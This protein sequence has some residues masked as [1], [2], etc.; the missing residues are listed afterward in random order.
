MFILHPLAVSYSH[1]VDYNNR[2]SI[3]L[4][5]SSPSHTLTRSITVSG[6]VSTRT[7]AWPSIPGT[8]NGHIYYRHLWKT[9]VMQ[10]TIPVLVSS[11][12]I[13]QKGVL[14]TWTRKD[15][16]HSREI[17]HACQKLYQL[18]TRKVFALTLRL[19]Q[20]QNKSVLTQSREGD[21]IAKICPKVVKVKFRISSYKR[22]R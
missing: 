11:I 2:Q 12:G 5:L 16:Q 21:P 22:I 17:M 6:P 13:N 18:I 20:K 9:V 4:L 15:Q 8:A 10:L 19:I 1:L 7:L 14:Q 3:L